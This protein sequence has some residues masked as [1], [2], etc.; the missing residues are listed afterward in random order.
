VIQGGE[1]F[2]VSS[3]L[4]AFLFFNFVLLLFFCLIASILH[5]G[6]V[7]LCLSAWSQ[8]KG[9]D[10]AGRADERER[11]KKGKLCGGGGGFRRNK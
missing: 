6:C 11:K 5:N 7:C 10:E 1:R 2:F 9:G 3:R 4:S 8:T